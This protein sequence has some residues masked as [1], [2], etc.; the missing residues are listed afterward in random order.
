MTD[1]SHFVDARTWKRAR[2]LL[3][4]RPREPAYTAKLKLQGLKIYVRD[5]K[6]RELP[7]GNRTLKEHSGGF[8]WSQSS[9]TA[10]EAR[11]LALDVSYGCA[12]REE[13]IA[14]HAGR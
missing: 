3:E 14:G 5:H 9:H 11:R 12:P 10:D 13:R 6:R 8:V 2:E 1:H 4:F 7:K